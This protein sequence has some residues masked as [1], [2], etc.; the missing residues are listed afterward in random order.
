[1]RSITAVLLHAR[2]RA[3]ARRE[4]RPAAHL[5]AR[6]AAQQAALAHWL[7]TPAHRRLPHPEQPGSGSSRISS[8]SPTANGQT[9]VKQ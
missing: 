5:A 8:L 2:A 4:G 7:S 1:M 6:P 3:S 9:V